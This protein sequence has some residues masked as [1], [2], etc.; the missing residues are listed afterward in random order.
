MRLSRILSRK[1]DENCEKHRLIKIAETCLVTEKRNSVC[2]I[3]SS[4][5]PLGK[6]SNSIPIKLFSLVFGGL[7]II[8]DRGGAG[9][10]VLVWPGGPH[11]AQ[12]MEILSFGPCDRWRLRL[13]CVELLRFLHRLFW[14][15]CCRLFV[16]VSGCVW[17]WVCLCIFKWTCAKCWDGRICF[18]PNKASQ[19][20]SIN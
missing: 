7:V 10:P 20:A 9:R 8:W 16:C 2:I 11:Q 3:Y 12:G 15:S 6:N 19:Q 4:S 1:K 18:C 14:D 13:L 5:M 17:L